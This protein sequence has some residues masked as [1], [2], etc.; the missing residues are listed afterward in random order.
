[1]GGHLWQSSHATSNLTVTTLF[2]FFLKI[3]IILIIHVF[4]IRVLNYKHGDIIFIWIRYVNA[5]KLTTC[6]YKACP[7][8][9]FIY[10]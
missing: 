10:K 2:F 8:D 9:P 5:E 3:I 6:T 1:M 4:I 7:S